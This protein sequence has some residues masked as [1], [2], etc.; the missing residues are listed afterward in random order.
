MNVC[1]NMARVTRKELVEY[2]DKDETKV[3]QLVYS[4][5]C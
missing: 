5:V 4:Q 3:S 2:E 1:S